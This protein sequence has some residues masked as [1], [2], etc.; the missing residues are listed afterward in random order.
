MQI[1]DLYWINAIMKRN[2]K[3]RY[4][5]YIIK[6]E[7]IEVLCSTVINYSFSQITIEHHFVTAICGRLV[8]SRFIVVIYF[9]Y[10]DETTIRFIRIRLFNNIAYT[11]LLR[12]I[13][14]LIP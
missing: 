5:F 7:E 10:F 12:I 11:Q 13:S 3:N 6:F 1:I 4:F 8:R 9:S 14:L 2:S